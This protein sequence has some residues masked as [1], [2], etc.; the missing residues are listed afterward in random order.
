VTLCVIVEISE[1][2]K[3]WWDRG[4]IQELEDD[5]EIGGTKEGANEVAEALMSLFVFYT[6]II[7]H[8]LLIF[9]PN[10]LW[11][12]QNSYRAHQATQSSGKLLGRARGLPN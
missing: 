2:L 3:N 9:A 8:N 12:S 5:N 1:C 4:L 6:I 11:N 10:R 7:A